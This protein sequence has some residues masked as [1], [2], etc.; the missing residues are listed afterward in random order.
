LRATAPLARSEANDYKTLA[1][2][3]YVAQHDYFGKEQTA[4]EQEHEL[5]A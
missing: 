3:N 4:L 1:R 5:A 2:D